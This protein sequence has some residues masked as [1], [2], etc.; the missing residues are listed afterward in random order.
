MALTASLART[1]VLA[2]LIAQP[3]PFK[4]TR[5]ALS[6]FELIMPDLPLSYV[7]KNASISLVSRSNGIC[8]RY[9]VK[10][11]LMRIR[12]SVFSTL[13][14]FVGSHARSCA[15]TSTFASARSSRSLSAAPCL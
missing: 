12:N 2:M 4:S 3:T 5:I 14:L 13:P 1:S 7:S 6:S 11:A 10:S 15:G 8:G 9:L